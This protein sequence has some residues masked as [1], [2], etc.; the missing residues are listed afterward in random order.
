ME[1]IKVWERM[2]SHIPTVARIAFQDLPVP[3]AG[4]DVKGSFSY[5]KL[6]RADK[7]GCHTSKHHTSRVSFAVN[8]VEP[9]IKKMKVPEADVGGGPRR[10]G[11][12][13]FPPI[14]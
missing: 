1:L 3:H 7:Q 14:F 11:N 10:D 6:C 13:G 8:G 12:R 5:F 4:L 9:P 2:Q